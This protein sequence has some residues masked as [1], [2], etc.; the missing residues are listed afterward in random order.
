MDDG[1]RP[2]SYELSGVIPSNLFVRSERPFL[3]L[4]FCK[5]LNFK[6]VVMKTLSAVRCL[7][8][9][10]IAVLTVACSTAPRVEAQWADVSVGANPA[11]LRGTL[12]AVACDAQD[13]TVR[14]IC[15]DQL[16]R[17]IT[18]RGARPAPVA[19]R[20]QSSTYQSP[21]DELTASARAMGAD[22]V[23]LVTVTPAVTDV[24]PGVSIGIGGFG[25]GRNSAL[26]LGLTA[27]IG[28]GQVSTGYAASG[29][30]ADVATGRMLWSA[31]VVAPPSSELSVQIQE[32][33]GVLLQSAQT[34]GLF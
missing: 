34:A 16:V 9:A 12:V 1:S 15:Q 3:T 18:Q 24:S 28:G 6:D 23:L 11:R 25:F 10:G 19:A 33:S 22:A 8:I 30:I 29:R 21:D 17:E 26:G 32:L 5:A 20:T 31:T 14:Q 27:P 4:L 13:V 2:D 7:C